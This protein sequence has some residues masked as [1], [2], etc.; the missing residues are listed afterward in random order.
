[1]STNYI[2]LL[3]PSEGK[4]TGGD[5]SKPTRIVQNFKKYNNFISLNN[6]RELILET[7]QN[8]IFSKGLGIVSK[9]NSLKLKKIISLAEDT[10][11]LE[12]IFELKEKNLQDAIEITCD[13][14]NEGTMPTISR[15]DGVMF[16]AINYENMSENLKNNFNYSVLF[17]DGMFGLLKPQDLIPRY[18]LKITS[19]IGEINITK[20]WRENLGSYFRYLFKEKLVIDILPSAHR[21][22][23]KFDEEDNYVSIKFCKIKDNKLVNVGHDSKKLKGDLIN[24]IVSFEN[25]SRSD[26]EKFEHVDGY[27]FSEKY[28]LKNELV[29]LKG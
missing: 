1:M 21:K 18:K 16:K 20:Y 11:E 8:L 28:S 13:L 14:L 25:I 3:P 10:K 17:I 26:L 29:Y 9:K 15:Y 23:V 6:D 27:K 12:K 5:S 2:I 24:Y 19:K 22:V 7:L 4:K